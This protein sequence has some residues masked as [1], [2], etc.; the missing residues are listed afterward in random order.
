MTNLKNFFVAVV[1]FVSFS[2]VVAN[3]ENHQNII[4]VFN[5]DIIED[6]TTPASQVKM[7]LNQ[8]NSTRLIELGLVDQ[9]NF[10]STH[11]DWDLHFWTQA[12]SSPDGII[13]IIQAAAM[14]ETNIGSR[15]ASSTWTL[16]TGSPL[17]EDPDKI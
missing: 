8:K 17:T 10:C 13:V 5:N 2:V 14:L 4:N 1:V 16:C 3:T 6:S 11:K 7:A 12:Y 9:A 15:I